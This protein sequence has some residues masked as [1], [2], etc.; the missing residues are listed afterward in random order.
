MIV[1][2]AGLSGLNAARRLMA[3]GADVVVVEARDRVGGRTLSVSHHG[4]VFDHGAQWIGP[5]QHRVHELVRELGLQTFPQFHNGTKVM[6]IRGKRSSYRGAIPSMSIPGLLVAE[7]GLRRLDAMASK[8]PLRAPQQAV[9]AAEWD[10]QTLASMRRK[11]VPHRDARAMFDLAVRTVFGAEPSELSL[12]Y[13]LFYVHT[14]GG[15]RKLVEIEGCA[16]QDRLVEGTQTLSARLA[17]PLGDRVVL[18]S[19]VRVI[20]QSD[21]GVIVESERARVS[22]KAAIVAI[23]PHLVGHLRFEP[24][25]PA[26]RGQLL[27]RC[28]MGATTKVIA[29]YPEASWRSRGL[30]GE[31]VCDGWPISCVFDNSPVNGSVGALVGFVVGEHARRWSGLALADRR[32]LALDVF[33]DL[34]GPPASSAL[35]Y[36][37]QDWAAEPWTGGC[38]VAVL[39]A[40]AMTSFGDMLRAPV[41]RV[42]FAGTETA[43]HW[44]GY[45]EGA[46]EAGERA[47]VEVLARL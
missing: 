18:S 15:F 20:H 14:A 39:P 42:S 45:L 33:A 17:E 1:V 3:L 38:P 34:I 40:G 12:L 5:T 7:L 35:D 9:S 37:E 21:D 11:L 6:D 30:S 36:F 44:C 31:A 10:S 32:R 4:A 23:P 8:V 13:F 16:Q 26:R 24:A 25:L 47:A 19:P 2:G 22:A 41:G 43:Q 29:L 28:G 46:L 27:Q